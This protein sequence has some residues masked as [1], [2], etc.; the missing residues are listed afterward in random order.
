MPGGCCWDRNPCGLPSTHDRKFHSLRSVLEV[1]RTSPGGRRRTRAG[2]Q[3]VIDPR[4]KQ[5]EISHEA[6]GILRPAASCV[7]AAS[8]D[9]DRSRLVCLP[10]PGFPRIQP[11]W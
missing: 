4:L 7:L 9:T 10:L 2:R 5:A 6:P 1:L 11:I 8:Q 3:V